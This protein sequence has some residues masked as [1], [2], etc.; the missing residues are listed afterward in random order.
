MA[1]SPSSKWCDEST[2]LLLFD[3]SGD[4]TATDTG[5]CH[6][7]KLDDAPP[8]GLMGPL[9]DMDNAMGGSSTFRSKLLPRVGRRKDSKRSQGSLEEPALPV[10]VEEE[11]N[12]EAPTDKLTKENSKPSKRL[13]EIAFA[14]N[15][16]LP[17]P[18]LYADGCVDDNKIIMLCQRQEMERLGMTVSSGTVIIKKDTS[19]LIGISIGGGAPLCPCLYIVQVFD[20]TP[21]A[22]EGTLQSGDEL[23]GVNGVSVKGKTKVEVAKMIQSATDEVTVH[24]NKLHA[25]PTQGETLDIVLKKMKH[26]LVEKMSSSTADTLGLSRA[27]L[28]NDSLVKRLQELERTETM[29]KGLVDHARRM[30]KAHF[31]VLQTYQAFGNVFASISVREP[32]PRASEAFR[33]FGELHRSMEKD[34]IKMIKSLKPILADM[35]TYLHKAIPDTKLTV[36]RY[37]DAKFSYLSY[38]LKIKEMDDEE[39]GYA[40]IQEPLYRVET[41]NYE[42][43]LILRCRQE[44]RLKFAKLRSDVLEKIELL[45]CK[46]ARD[47]AS[48][49][50]KFIEGLA[51]LATETVE[52]LEAI[53]NLF[54]IEVDLKASA[55]QYKSAIKFQAEEYVDDV[56]TVQAE[57][58]LEERETK[59]RSESQPTATDGVSRPNGTDLEGQLLSGFDEVDLGKGSS[60]GAT[61][62]ND[63]LDEL[64]LAGIDLSIGSKPLSGNLMDDLLGPEL[65]LFK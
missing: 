43:R 46:H 47:L 62:Q 24:Y 7:A 44:A 28:C 6:S 26:R 17:D 20:G 48:Q 32:Q 21:A 23:L 63:L 35:G 3:E 50:R 30:L 1:E 31:D 39:H 51:T 11:Q 64:G 25:D 52:R 61:A 65:D 49:L 60:N 13:E 5:S 12:A 14:T 58:A 57:E 40:A 36:K 4:K 42:Y 56:E 45:E 15:D 38:C 33:V 8:N 53:P 18:V 29:Y 2:A 22:R 9:I 41:G 55:F 10:G 16:D 54:P 37:A 27:I 19:N 59:V 34:G